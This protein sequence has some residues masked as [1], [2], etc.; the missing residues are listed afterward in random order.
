MR[1]LPIVML[2]GLT[3]LLTSTTALAQHYRHPASHGGSDFAYGVVPASV[4][5]GSYAAVG[6]RFGHGYSTI[7]FSQVSYHGYGH[8]SDYGFGY[9]HRPSHGY[10]RRQNH[11]GHR[12]RHTVHGQAGHKQSHNGYGHNSGGHAQKS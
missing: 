5:H 10:G 4:S 7:G 12:Q 3:G 2:L 8:G 11:S 9:D 1:T 6:L